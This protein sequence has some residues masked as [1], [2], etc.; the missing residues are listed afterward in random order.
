MQP[1]DEPFFRSPFRQRDEVA[2]QEFDML[3]GQQSAFADLRTRSLSGAPGTGVVMASPIEPRQSFDPAL[4]HI[5]AARAAQLPA[6]V[7]VAQVEPISVDPVSP[8]SAPDF[9]DEFA[10]PAPS[11]SSRPANTAPTKSSYKGPNVV[12]IMT[13]GATRN[14]PLRPELQNILNTTAG[15]LGLRVEVFSGGQPS[16]GPHRVGSHRH[17]HG[18]ATD[19]RIYKGDR[20]LSATNKADIPILRQFATDAYRLGASNIGAGPGYMNGNMH[21]GI[22]HAGGGSVG[23]P[24]WGAGGKS[25]NTPS[26]LRAAYGDR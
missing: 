1:Y 15:N 9:G 26:W 17:D 21:V 12:K 6:P 20:L 10:P 4:P 22:N 2:D 25:K 23:S 3:F 19:I 11:Q 8:V 13:K 14:K 5:P 7:D 18:S 24:Y 16:S